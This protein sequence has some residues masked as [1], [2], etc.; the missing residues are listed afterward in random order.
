MVGRC[1][2]WRHLWWWHLSSGPFQ[3]WN[4]TE[5]VRRQWICGIGQSSC[6]EDTVPVLY[7][8]IHPYSSRILALTRAKAWVLVRVRGTTAVKLQTVKP[9]TGRCRW[10]MKVLA[11]VTRWQSGR[12]PRS[13][14]FF[15]SPEFWDSNSPEICAC[16]VR[17]LSAHSAMFCVFD[18]T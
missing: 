17:S 2:Q 1:W 11:P 10:N 8:Y 14:V 6:N 7:I 12:R 13:L 3:L 16:F 15:V 4:F 18:I 9:R 5:V